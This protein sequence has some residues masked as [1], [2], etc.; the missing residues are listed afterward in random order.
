MYYATTPDSRDVQV[1]QQASL[2]SLLSP[3]HTPE[4]V[5]IETVNSEGERT[6]WKVFVTEVSALLCV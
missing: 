6:L 2:D 4:H 5:V 3:D 1:R